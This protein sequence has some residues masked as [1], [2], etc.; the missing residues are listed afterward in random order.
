[1][2]FLNFWI[3]SRNKLLKREK[4]DRNASKRQKI[5]EEEEVLVVKE[6][7]KDGMINFKYFLDLKSQ[8]EEANHELKQDTKKDALSNLLQ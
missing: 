4:D 5:G 1:M 8:N 3:W 7:V 6:K 2:A